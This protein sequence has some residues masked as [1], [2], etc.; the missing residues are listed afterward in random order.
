M[1]S[2]SVDVPGSFF[3]QALVEVVSKTSGF[4]LDVLSEE[5]DDSFE[6]YVAAMSL[7]SLKGGI[8]FISVG[9]AGLRTLCSYI[10][11]TPEE[12]ISRADLEDV[13]C[14]LLNMTAGNAKLYLN[15]TEFMYSLS[16]PVVINGEN[17]SIS[18][19][20]RANVISRTLGNGEIIV[21][22]KVVY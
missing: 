13:L 15:D 2:V 4:S 22:L 1:K 19:K 8:I 18:T 17:L 5:R 9:E 11:G 14:E 7:N 20:K 10:E 6:E 12:N 3:T 16:T 21:R